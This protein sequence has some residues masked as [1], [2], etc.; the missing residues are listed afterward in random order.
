[1]AEYFVDIRC[2]VEA[3]SIEEAIMLVDEQTMID[4]SLESFIKAV[5]VSLT[6]RDKMVGD[7]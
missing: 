3:D 6:D 5:G 2:K 7:D 1:M 4:S